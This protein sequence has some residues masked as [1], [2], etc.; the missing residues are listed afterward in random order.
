MAF[1]VSDSKS[2]TQD[3]AVPVQS[4]P[5]SEHKEKTTWR[6]FLWDSWDKSPEERKLIFKVC[7]NE[8]IVKTK[9][10]KLCR[11][12]DITLLTFGCLGTFIKYIDM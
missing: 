7:D 4:R 2:S 3:A 10:A 11:Q 9:L 5:K 6:N 1:L 12:M 8:H